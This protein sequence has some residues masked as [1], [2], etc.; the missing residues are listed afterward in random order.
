M[1]DT[2]IINSLNGIS[3]EMK[4]YDYYKNVDSDAETYETVNMYY[5]DIA[6]NGKAH[7]KVTIGEYRP[8][9][10]SQNEGTSSYMCQSDN[11]Y[12]YGT[13]FFLFE[14]IRWKVLANEDSG[15][16]V[17]SEKLLDSPYYISLLFRSHGRLQVCG[18]GLMISGS[19]EN[20]GTVTITGG[21]VEARGGYEGAGIGTGEGANCTEIIISGGTVYAE[22]GYYAA[23]IGGGGQEGDIGA[24]CGDITITAGVIQV[25]AKKG[26]SE[27]W[28]EAIGR[29]YEGS[30]GTVTIE[31]GANVI[32]N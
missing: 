2:A 22:G 28:I 32:T 8:M 7:R 16:Y 27:E 6:F 10:C 12:T 11:G 14:P 17:M 4:Q 1:T 18:H 21:D 29:G 9:Y 20:C 5:A 30:C 19:E 13:Y 25:T 24:T 23:G 31:P 3:C 15:V 26:R